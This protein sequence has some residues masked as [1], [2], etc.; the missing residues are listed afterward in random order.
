[1]SSQNQER[2]KVIVEDDHFLRM[3]RVILDPDAPAEMVEAV[4]DFMVHDEP[5]FR[6]WMRRLRARLDGLWPAHVVMVHSHEELTQ[7]LP[8]ADVAVVEGER[9][10]KEEIALAPKLK[11]IQKYGSLTRG[12][13]VAACRARS[14]DVLTIRRRANIQCA[15]HIFALMLSLSRKI[16]TYANCLTPE[17]FAERGNMLRP[18]DRRFTP[19]GN[20][21]RIPGLR[22][23][24]ESTIGIIG[25]GEIGREVAIRANAFGMRVLYHQRTQLPAEEERRYAATYASLSDLLGASDWVVPQ[26]PG[27]PET[28]GLIDATRLAQ[29]KRGAMIVNVSRADLIDRDALIS[30]LASGHLGGV[31][32]DPPYW[33]PGRTDDELMQFENV[34]I[35]PHFGGS[36]RQNALAD[37]EEMM[38]GI[39]SVLQRRRTA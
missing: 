31:G 7:H 36:P 32:L 30:A 10:G 22:A 16:H 25:L 33:S 6:G 4:C 21:A 8:S 1:M 34:V 2:P 38:M 12:V 13:D 26:I 17:Q 27:T 19:N 37:F 20:W 24:N 28:R 3:F 29:M 15:E 35:T 14:I 11:A 23:L 39:A 18:F 5:D 9:I